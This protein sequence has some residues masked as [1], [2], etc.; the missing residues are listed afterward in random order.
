MMAI[1]SLQRP[2][3]EAATPRLVP[4]DQLTA[5][6]AIMS[7]STNAS[8][9][10]GSSL[11]GLLAAAP[12]PWLVY[13]LDAAGF[14]VSFLML[15]RL[16][17]LPPVVGKQA[18]DECSAVF[19]DTMWNQSIPDHLRGR[20]AGIELLS[21]AAGPPAGQLRSGAV[22]AVTSVRFSLASGGL[23]CVA[24]VTGVVAVLPAF[25]RYT[26]PLAAPAGQPAYPEAG[27]PPGSR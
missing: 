21:Y 14:A 2:A 17:E 1:A 10:A 9:L 7:L 15:S 16:P 19:R 26:A 8:V 27:L 6:A 25:R 12:G 22:A 3:F 4:R 24:A 13:A 20:M 11:G 23:A 5:A 18:R